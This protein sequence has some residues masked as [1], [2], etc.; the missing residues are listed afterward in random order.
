MRAPLSLLA[1]AGLLLA[2]CEARYALFGFPLPAPT[3]ARPL[4]IELEYREAKGGLVVL[5]G[6]VNDHSDVDFILDTGAPVSVLID[7]ARTAGL[8]LDSSKARPLGD[9]SNPGTPTGDIQGGFHVAFG[10]LALSDLTAVVIPQKTMPCQDKFEEVG[11][12]GVIGAALFRQF[13]VEVDAVGKRVRLHDPQ[14][15]KPPASATVV[16]L[17]FKSG[18]PFLETRITLA[19]GQVID[20][21]M[22]LDIGMNRALTLAAGS[23]PAIVMPTGGTPRKSCYVNGIRD[24]REG[25]PAKLHLAGATFDVAAPI[26]SAHPNAVDGN[27]TSTIGVGLFQERR[28][29]IDYP[30]KRLVLLP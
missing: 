1:A 14:S 21:P 2:G 11:F 17:T 9:P 28:I 13:V 22:N 12:G 27:R 6:R 5:R 29:A 16:P 3:L 20:A 15:W 24:E 23:H 7:G 26:Y 4:P 8:G 19:N 10:D 25:G 30:G 18:H